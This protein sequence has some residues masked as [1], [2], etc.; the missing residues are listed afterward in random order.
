M[1]SSLWQKAVCL[2]SPPHPGSEAQETRNWPCC[3]NTLET[4]RYSSCHQ[5]QS[6]PPSPMLSSLQP[7]LRRKS[8]LPS[9]AF[10][11][12]LPGRSSPDLSTSSSGREGDEATPLSPSPFQLTG[13]WLLLSQEAGGQGGHHFLRQV[14]IGR[15]IFSQGAAQ[16]N[17]FK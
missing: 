11:P 3:W 15:T 14:N 7:P 8:Q 1:P 17:I 10:Y 2:H 6:N 9:R 5:G 4:Y 16:L 13:R 12:L